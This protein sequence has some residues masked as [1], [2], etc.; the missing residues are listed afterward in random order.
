M[1][2]GLPLLDIILFAAIAGFLVLRL[3]SVLGKRTGHQERPQH[4]PFQNTGQQRQPGQSKAG[5]E[6]DKVIPMPGRGNGKDD[7]VTD[8]DLR[9][10]AEGAETPLSAGLTQIKLA[11]PNFD[12][13]TFVQGARSAFE[14]IVTAYAQGDRDTLRQFLAS[15]VY[16][17]FE[18][19]IRGH[20]QAGEKLETT[21]VSIREA[22][23]IEAELS[24]RTAFVTVKFLSDQVNVV[25]DAEGNVAEGDPEEVTEITD[26]WTFART[27]RSSDPNWTLVATRS[28][29][30][31][32]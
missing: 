31:E 3:R 24:D 16:N 30:G 17:D 23:I 32:S 6:R 1:E 14:M 20:E 18:Q 11:D 7:G 5:G 25:R 15:D 13:D 8:T 12:E 4:D 21:L 22:E 9:E 27:T 26:I 29:D 19:A 2:N 28:P 10:A